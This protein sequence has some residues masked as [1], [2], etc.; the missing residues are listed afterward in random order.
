VLGTE[1]RFFERAASV[2]NHWIISLAL[3]PDLKK[4]WQ[5]LDVDLWESTYPSCTR[6]WVQAP[7]LKKEKKHIEGLSRT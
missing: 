1:T 4:D 2:Y 7:F 3:I 5:G 6:L